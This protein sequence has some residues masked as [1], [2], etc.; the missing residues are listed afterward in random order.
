MG[1]QTIPWTTTCATTCI[2]WFE[3]EYLEVDIRN[4]KNKI[5]RENRILSLFL[6]RYCI[7][8]NENIVEY[9]KYVY[10]LAYDEKPKYGYLIELFGKFA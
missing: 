10:G 8:M 9:L 6:E 2:P 3:S 5:R 7:G 1:L 4:P